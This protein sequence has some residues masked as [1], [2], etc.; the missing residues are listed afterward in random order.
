MNAFGLAIDIP[1]NGSF[2]GEPEKCLRF[3]DC[4]QGNT[5]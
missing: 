4:D 1:A 5:L 3:R 2:D